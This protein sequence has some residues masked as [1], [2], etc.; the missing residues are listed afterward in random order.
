MPETMQQVEKS[1]FDSDIKSLCLN[2]S[3]ELN[4]E[5]YLKM[6]SLLINLFEKKYPKKSLFEQQ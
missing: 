4:Y 1:L 5:D 6:K 2:D 3:S